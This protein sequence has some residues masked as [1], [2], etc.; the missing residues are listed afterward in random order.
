MNGRSIRIFLPEGSPVQLFTAEIVNWTG[1]VTIFPR[2]ELSK[3]K[4]RP[5]AQQP[6]VYILIGENPEHPEQDVVYIGETEVL[7]DR[8]K[9]HNG[10]E[11]KDF[12]QATFA[13]SSK[14]ANL[15]KAHIRYL[16]ARM[17]E[18]VSQSGRAK[19]KNGTLI[20]SGQKSPLPEADQADMEYFLGQ[21]ALILPVVG[22]QGLRP[23]INT[24]PTSSLGNQTTPDHDPEIYPDSDQLPRFEIKMDQTGVKATAVESADEFVVLAGSTARKDAQPS[25]G[26]Y[27]QLRAQLESEGKVVPHADSGLLIFQEDVPFR[28]PS[29]AASV[30]LAR[31]ANGRTR[32]VHAETGKGYGD[33]KQQQLEADHQSP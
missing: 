17:I 24:R 33:F 3:F 16:E 25:W 13:I 28:S 27:R 20:S 23:K 29:A 5:E 15:T 12:W 10:S 18:L 8:L 2:A 14:D 9:Y 22:F 21:L 7:I 4:G 32:W 30:I 11:D 26:N 19:L 1:R 6:G 31:N